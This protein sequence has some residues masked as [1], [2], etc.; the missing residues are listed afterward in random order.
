MP[1]WAIILVNFSIIHDPPGLDPLLQS[2]FLPSSSPAYPRGL[3][4]REQFTTTFSGSI[5]YR[6]QFIIGQA[7]GIDNRRQGPP[8]R[9]SIERRRGSK[10]NHRRRVC[11]EMWMV[12]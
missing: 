10:L 2:I 8:L 3:D 6:A 4:N 5:V 11:F 12:F 1:L 7:P 9:G